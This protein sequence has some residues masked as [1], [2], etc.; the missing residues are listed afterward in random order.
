MLETLWFDMHENINMA[1][2]Y[3]LLVCK[4]R[5]CK[6][7]TTTNK[8]TKKK[9]KSRQFT[10]Q[11]YVYPTVYKSTQCHAMASTSLDQFPQNVYRPTCICP[12]EV[13]F[14]MTPAVFCSIQFTM[15]L[16]KIAT[17]YFHCA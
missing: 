6:T 17:S 10:I 3:S 13:P 7:T 4:N 11:V 9:K 5:I 1:I 8:Q 14:G 16:R 12:V 15:E 2:P